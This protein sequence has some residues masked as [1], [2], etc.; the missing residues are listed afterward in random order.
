MGKSNILEL[1]SST[2]K[3]MILDAQI[4]SGDKSSEKVERIVSAL[5]SAVIEQSQN[6]IEFAKDAMSNLVPPSYLPS[7]PD[8]FDLPIQFDSYF[9]DSNSYFTGTQKWMGYVLEIRGKGFTAKLED[10]T[11][12]GTYEIGEF[13]VNEISPGDMDL[14]CKGA[15]FY[16]SVGFATDKGQRKKESIIRFQRLPELTTADIFD[17]KDRASQLIDG[18]ILD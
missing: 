17:A 7:N 16:W 4:S 13:E 10:L 9:F 3:R 1:P 11:N 12:P 14:F 5:E 2:I 8:P 18:I 15:V 6:C